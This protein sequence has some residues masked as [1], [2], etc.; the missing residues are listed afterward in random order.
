MA[1]D[2]LPGILVARMAVER[3]DGMNID[4]VVSM[5][6][7]ELA[8]DAD[9]SLLL[10]LA[11]VKEIAEEAITPLILL[12]A[13]LQSRYCV[14]ALFNLTKSARDFFNGRRIDRFL[15]VCDD[16]TA[17][18]KAVA[19]KP[20]RPELKR[21]IRAHY[22]KFVPGHHGALD[23]IGGLPTHLPPEFPMTTKEVLEP[24]GKRRRKEKRLPVE[25]QPMAFTAQFYCTPER[26]NL[27]GALCV[28]VYQE[29]APEN[30]EMLGRSNPEVTP[31]DIEWETRMDPATRP[32][33]VFDPVCRVLMDSKIGGTTFFEDGVEPGSTFLLQIRDDRLGQTHGINFG[34][35]TMLL[36]AD[37]SGSVQAGLA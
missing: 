31:H 7:S 37:A 29:D 15:E 14:L 1:F 18:M 26:L 21:E 35:F 4:N 19:G 23:R 9:C 32:E 24:K 8:H 27:P 6:R 10:D 34:G 11:D 20:A 25:M 28:H 2:K 5:L 17:A 13:E 30:S 16:E 22:M 33:N 3:L 12:H 36:V